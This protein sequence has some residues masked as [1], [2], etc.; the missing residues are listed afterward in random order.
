M[1]EKN[2]RRQIN[3][4]IMNNCKIANELRKYRDLAGCLNQ[5]SLSGERGRKPSQCADYAEYYISENL[6]YLDMVVANAAY[7]WMVSS[8]AQ[9]PFQADTIGQIMAGNMAWRLPK[10]MKQDLE[11]RLQK[12]A[13]IELYILADHDHQVEPDLYEGTFLPLRW[14][15][16]GGKVKFHFLQGQAMPLYQYAQHH[17]QLIEVPFC[18]LRD[19][20]DGGQASHNNT[21]RML[22]LR[23]YLLQELEI[24]L[25]ENNKVK[26][27]Q[28]RL[29]KE[30]GEGN[31]LGLLW[32]L[33]IAPDIRQT[34]KD[35]TAVA[36]R[37]Q[38]MI[39]QLM[40]QWQKSGYLGSLQFQMLPAEEHFGVK[41]TTCQEKTQ[42]PAS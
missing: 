25:Y 4:F 37:M 22:A 18:R 8:P 38:K 12:L 7:T 6:T 2:S 31:E 23:H 30:D 28:I 11:A 39:G 21:D 16:E 13:G 42:V 40:E 1:A 32:I 9:V 29:L 36:K 41:I 34:D 26:E 3:R 19:N 27:K 17:R 35:L 14:E 20:Q 15:S 5:V 33:G 24:L 10:K